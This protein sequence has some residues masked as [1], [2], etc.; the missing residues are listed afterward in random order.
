MTNVAPH[1]LAITLTPSTA[2]EGA[3][4]TLKGSFI[5]PGVL[6]TH[7]L[8]IDWGD[9]SAP[10]EVDLA[11]GVLTFGNPGDSGLISH[12]Y[13][14][15]LPGNSPYMINVTV[16]ETGP[17]NNGTTSA[18][19]TSTVDNVPPTANVDAAPGGNNGVRGQLWPRR[20]AD[21]D[22]SFA[23]RPGGR[24]HLH[25]QLGRRHGGRRNWPERHDGQ[26]LLP[27]RR[28]APRTSD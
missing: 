18:T 21:G 6:D 2:D 16:S 26:P 5:D 9:G 28:P 19:A 23:D 14:D 3:S 4:T 20:H 27:G 15:N 13:E 11:A 24:F 7:T 10:T 17:G 22:R 25:R 1:D 12:T 8:T